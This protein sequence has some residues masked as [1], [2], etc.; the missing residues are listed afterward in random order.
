MENTR[1]C[2]FEIQSRSKSTRRTKVD[3]SFNYFSNNA[4]LWMPSRRR[5]L[6]AGGITMSP[7]HMYVF[8]VACRESP[9]PF[10][11]LEFSSFGKSFFRVKYDCTMLL[12]YV[13]A[14]TFTLW[15][16]IRYFMLQRFFSFFHQRPRFIIA[17]RVFVV[18]LNSFLFCFLI[19]LWA[20]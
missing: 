10:D 5:T 18:F 4:P 6:A 1:N 17:L 9:F 8:I 3:T 12:N 11:S 19:Q 20:L 13:L 16:Y 14:Y 15:R 7:F 2:Y